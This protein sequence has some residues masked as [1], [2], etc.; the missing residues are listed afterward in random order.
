MSVIDSFISIF[1]QG[2]GDEDTTLQQC[3]LSCHTLSDYK[4][5]EIQSKAI[6]K[7]ISNSAA[8][9]LNLVVLL[10]MTTRSVL[11]EYFQFEDAILDTIDT[12]NLPP[13]AQIPT[14]S[15]WDL[16]QNLNALWDDW[17]QTLNN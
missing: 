3:L 5:A 1:A 14:P 13:A 6:S 8:L 12:I 15:P 10:K 16:I 9:P 17:Q 7:L 2:L 11:R 4:Q